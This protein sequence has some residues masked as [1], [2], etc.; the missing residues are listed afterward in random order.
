MDFLLAATVAC[1]LACAD[2]LPVV[3]PP[4][5][6]PTDAAGMPTR[7]L[8]DEEMYRLLVAW[9]AVSGDVTNALA[10]CHPLSPVWRPCVEAWAASRAPGAGR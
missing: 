7:A 3:R 10:A 1:G 2:A 6:I 9:S 5:D 4:A 8:S